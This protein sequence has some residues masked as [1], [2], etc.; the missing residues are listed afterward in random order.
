[1]KHSTPPGTAVRAHTRGGGRQSKS[2][3]QER[4][5]PEF[6]P[7]VYWSIWILPVKLNL[8][9]HVLVKPMLDTGTTHCFI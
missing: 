3:R 1:M 4:N 2:R 9:T 7:I 6:K 8:N 5:N